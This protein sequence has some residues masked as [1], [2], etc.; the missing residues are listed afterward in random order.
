LYGSY[1]TQTNM[2]WSDLDLFFERS[3]NGRV[4]PEAVPF[5]VEAL[6]KAASLVS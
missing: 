1:G 6:L 3:T 2:P 5:E 4:P